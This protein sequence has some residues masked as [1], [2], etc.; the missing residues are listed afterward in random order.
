MEQ[1][2]QQ[3]LQSLEFSVSGSSKL[4]IVKNLVVPEGSVITKGLEDIRFL[5]TENAMQTLKR[6]LGI[7]RKKHVVDD[8]EEIIVVQ[9]DKKSVDSTDE[10]ESEEESFELTEESE[11][12]SD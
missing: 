10:P 3:S 6:L 12:E 5:T 2:S 7:R 11:V 4:V 1:G 8:E 9:D